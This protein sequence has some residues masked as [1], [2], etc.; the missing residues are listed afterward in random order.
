MDPARVMPVGTA[1]ES[2]VNSSRYD[3]QFSA[4]SEVVI[5]HRR[6]SEVAV[7][8]GNEAKQRLRDM[9]EAAEWTCGSDAEFAAAAANLYARLREAEANASPAEA[10]PAWAQRAQ[11]ALEAFEP[12]PA[13]ARGDCAHASSA[14]QSESP[15]QA[16]KCTEANKGVGARETPF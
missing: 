10:S 6:L 14:A 1:P 11:A 13:E 3:F 4:K 8:W 5:K 7:G 9:L 16:K 2:D 12:G 15:Q